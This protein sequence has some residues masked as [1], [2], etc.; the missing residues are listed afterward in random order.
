[1]MS[2][3]YV[4]W[5]SIHETTCC[6]MGEKK[7]RNY[8]TTLNTK[9]ST[10]FLPPYW[11]TTYAWIEAP[12]AADGTQIDG[13]ASVT[14]SKAPRHPP[15]QLHLSKTFSKSAVTP[16]AGFGDRIAT[17]ALEICHQ[18]VL[19]SI[20]INIVQHNHLIIWLAIKKY[21][22]I[23]C[24]QPV[25]MPQPK[26]SLFRHQPL[27]Q[28][29]H[30]L[31]MALKIPQLSSSFCPS[32]AQML[33]PAQACMHITLTLGWCSQIHLTKPDPLI[34]CAAVVQFILWTMS[35]HIHL[36]V[37]CK[38]GGLDSACRWVPKYRCHMQMFTCEELT[39]ALSGVQMS[40]LVHPKA[41]T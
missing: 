15:V 8:Q 29:L 31:L 12:E 28:Y 10:L 14:A 11:R 1:M 38:K 30:L 18:T 33:E 9:V 6:S 41:G 40:C 36:A 37:N 2:F 7:K 23:W 3:P 19:C 24:R 4:K 5:H 26:S 25:H 32:G 39:W 27:F 34:C 16:D 13:T 21:A 35:W 22:D 17:W 20:L